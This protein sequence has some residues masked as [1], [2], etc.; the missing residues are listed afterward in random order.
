MSLRDSLADAAREARQ[1]AERV[2]NDVRG[3]PSTA[4]AHFLRPNLGPTPP[5]M[6]RVLEPI[7]A[8]SAMLALFVLG[9]FGSACLAGMVVAG[10]LIY[11]IVTYVFGIE[12]NL[13]GQPATG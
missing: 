8:A 12:V 6:R 7:V 9:G 2:W 1:T 13:A 10:A 11:A 5:A 4:M 3:E